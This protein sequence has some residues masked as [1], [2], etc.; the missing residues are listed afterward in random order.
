MGRGG[1]WVRACQDLAVRDDSALVTA[2]FVGPRP[3]HLAGWS[4]SLFKR[5]LVGRPWASQAADPQ[6]LPKRIALPVFSL[7][8]CRSM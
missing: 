3:H 2:G 6:R 4:Y 5:V 8:R 7:M 1:V